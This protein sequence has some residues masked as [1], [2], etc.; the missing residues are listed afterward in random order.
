MQECGIILFN[1][2]SP[3]RCVAIAGCIKRL[4]NAN[5][6]D[7]DLALAQMSIFGIESYEYRSMFSDRSATEPW[8]DATRCPVSHEVLNTIT[9]ALYD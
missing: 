9:F 4:A 8:R 2:L 1:F 6:N 7:R 5:Y 3:W